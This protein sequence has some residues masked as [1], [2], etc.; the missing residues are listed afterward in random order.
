M[1]LPP[2]FG[3]LLIKLKKYLA[4]SGDLVPQAVENGAGMIPVSSLALMVGFFAAF[5]SGLIAC[6]WMIN[7]VKK[8]KLIYFAM[9]CFVVGVFAVLASLLS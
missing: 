3:A 1:V 5:F 2:I 7:L 4:S 6:K 8:S 9:Y